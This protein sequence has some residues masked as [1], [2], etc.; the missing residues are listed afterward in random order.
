MFVVLKTLKISTIGS[1]LTRSPKLKI[2]VSR[3]SSELKLSLKR[4][5]AGA[6]GKGCPLTPP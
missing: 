3:G 5:L 1:S 6:S 4:A 2:F